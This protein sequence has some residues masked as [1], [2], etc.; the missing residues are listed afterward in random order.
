MGEGAR[1]E[2]EVVTKKIL[3]KVFVG[4][5]LLSRREESHIETLPLANPDVKDAAVIG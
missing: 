5:S 2:P 1:L 3:G 4:R